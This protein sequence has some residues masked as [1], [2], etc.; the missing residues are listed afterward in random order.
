M[1]VVMLLVMVAVLTAALLAE[2]LF[3]SSLAGLLALGVLFAVVARVALLG[4]WPRGRRAA[5]RTP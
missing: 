4:V 3:D 2:A 5:R 1:S